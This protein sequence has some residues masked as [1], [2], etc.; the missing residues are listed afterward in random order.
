MEVPA[1][2]APL[3][4]SPQ[5]ELVET[6]AVLELPAGQRA[7]II[8][9]SIVVS[10]TP[11][12]LHNFIFGMLMR[13]LHPAA[14]DN[15]WMLT[16]T[17]TVHVPATDEHF[18]PDLVVIPEEI[19]LARCDDWIVP[20]E[21]VLLSAEITSTSTVK[22]DRKTKLW[23]S[24]HSMIPVYLLIDPHDG[25]GSASVHSE[26]DGEGRYQRHQTVPF[27]EKLTL[28][29]PFAVDLDTTAFVRS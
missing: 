16:N 12:M 8:G 28:P 14:V 27:G 25:V 26:P 18:A 5:E 17:A 4:G 24:A 23:S 3:F 29:E 6:F 22:R 19:L 9:G 20:A 7:E 2:T 11:T 21:S 1:M 10:P 15:G 13:T